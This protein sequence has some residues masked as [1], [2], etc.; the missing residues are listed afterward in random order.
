MCK[1]RWILIILL[2]LG[3]LAASRAF[4]G[5]RGQV[6]V[7]CNQVV[8]VQPVAQHPPG[9]D[10]G[11]KQGWVKKGDNVPPGLDKNYHSSGKYPKGLQ[12][13]R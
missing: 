1:Q 6:P 7:P 2:P 9:W 13:P 4:A 12:K 8:V 5:G 11:K 10:R 3:L